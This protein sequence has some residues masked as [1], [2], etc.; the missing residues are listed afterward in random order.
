MA[1]GSLARTATN[2]RGP[3]TRAAETAVPHRSRP[4]VH[5]AILNWNGWRDVV[6]G[7]DSRASLDCR[8]DVVLLVD[9]LARRGPFHQPGACA[10]QAARSPVLR[11]TGW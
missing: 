9:S 2:H 3:Q 1:S 4:L 6:E 7:L 5:T 11:Y 8:D 10:M